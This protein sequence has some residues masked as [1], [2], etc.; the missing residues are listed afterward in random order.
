MIRGYSSALTFTEDV[1]RDGIAM[2]AGYLPPMH[3]FCA[4]SLLSCS[5]A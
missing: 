4:S 5:T 2:P 3:F 1:R